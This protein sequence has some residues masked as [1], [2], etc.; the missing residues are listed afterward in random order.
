MQDH[1]AWAN[2]NELPTVDR[3]ELAFPLVVIDFEATA[4]TFGSYPIEVGV[5]RAMNAR[6]PFESWSTLIVPD[7]SWDLSS[8][9][10]PDAQRIH[11]IAKWD[12]RDGHSP[13]DTICALNRWVGN[14]PH[15]WCDGGQY[16]IHWL[17]TL[18][19]AAGIEPTF[20]LI[21]IRPL[22]LASPSISARYMHA[23]NRSK[24][25]HRA[26]LDAV[27]ICAALLSAMSSPAA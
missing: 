1:S 21:D 8:Q 16:D 19:A 23:L 9:W 7:P 17:D 2:D 3:L 22:M 15:V 10:D 4:L 26:E 6:H 20:S 13:S 14:A 18:A 27:R 25:P 12:L 24:P 11:G 5:A